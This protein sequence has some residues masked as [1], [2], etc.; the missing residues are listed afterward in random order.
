VKTGSALNGSFTVLVGGATL[1]NP[2]G[3]VADGAMAQPDLAQTST[4]SS[5]TPDVAQPGT[6]IVSRGQVITLAPGAINGAVLAQKFVSAGVGAVHYATPPVQWN[7]DPVAGLT[8]VAPGEYFTALLMNDGSV[9]IPNTDPNG[10]MAVERFAFPTS[11]VITDV[12]GGL[13][14]GVFLDSAGT[15]WTWGTGWSGMFSLAGDGTGDTSGALAHIQK[16]AMG[17]AFSNVV[18]VQGGG[19][20]DA[21]IKSD[22]TL[23]IWGDTTGGFTGDGTNG[24]KLN[25]PT[26][27]PFA[28]GVK[29][30]QIWFGDVA[31]ALDTNGGVWTWGG[32]TE[33]GLQQ[34]LGRTGSSTTPG[35][36][37]G[38]PSNIVSVA[39]GGRFEYALTADGKLYGWGFEGDHLGAGISPWSQVGA[40]DLSPY[41]KLPLPVQAVAANSETT[42]V[43]LS[44]GTLWGWGDDAYGGVGD[45]Q[46][47]DYS[48]TM[49]PYAWDWGT[50]YLMVY[51]PVQIAASEGPFKALYKN[52]VDAFY[53]FAVTADGHL[54]SWGRNKTANLM[55]GIVP[56]NPVAGLIGATFANSWDVL[57]P[58]KVNPF[59]YKNTEV[60]STA[61][62]ATPTTNGCQTFDIATNKDL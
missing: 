61:C 14:N 46:E 40:V 37:S 29:I 10:P 18:S 4:L 35:K 11:T 34:C 1:P 62:L 36:V 19:S 13:H 30:K 48:K 33:Y 2:D 53:T 41:L 47:L 50:S 54:Y 59:Q 44:D 42:H 8:K 12:A 31:V 28:S 5:T 52:N 43:I 21:A 45:G 27:V 26:Q 24:G 55:N 22:G 23:W 15:V 7:Y 25:S 39:A 60:S 56:A 58:M 49:A 32:G 6:A 20:F 16:D 51:S 3:G 38:L 17:A 9:Q 57:V